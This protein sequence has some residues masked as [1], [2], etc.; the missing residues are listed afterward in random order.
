MSESDNEL[1]ER[2]RVRAFYIWLNDG[3]PS[4]LEEDCWFRAQSQE[5]G[6]LAQRPEEPPP[7]A[8][9][10]AEF[11]ESEEGQ[12][13]HGQTSVVF[14]RQSDTT[15]SAVPVLPDRG[16]GAVELE[17]SIANLETCQMVEKKKGWFSKS[18]GRAKPSTAET[19]KVVPA[20]SAPAGT[21]SGAT[22]PS[23]TGGMAEP[24]NPVPP[25]APA[26]PSESESRVEAESAAAPAE[27]ASTIDATPET[28]AASPPPKLSA[29]AGLRAELASQALYLH[30]FQSS[31]TPYHPG[32]GMT[33]AIKKDED[34]DEYLELADGAADAQSGGP[35]NG[36]SLRLPDDVERA[37]SGNRIIVR[38]VARAAGGGV[39]R[40]AL[41]YST[42]EVGNSAW[43]WFTVDAAW[44][45]VAFEYAVNPM[46]KGNGDFIGVLAEPRGKPGIDICCVSVEIAPKAAGG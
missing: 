1:Q 32:K 30:D 15:K 12:L 39:S 2:I 26:T 29:R 8:S 33:A 11:R 24:E 16:D 31:T 46:I 21:S 28:G 35:T 34:G 23:K 41:A 36:Y 19:A 40:L 7:P 42:N 37:A 3:C 14:S 22:T 44:S 20:P 6:R 18:L 45:A 27:F 9:L 13:T 43:R 17:P 10:T 4:G 5:S 38:G 25:S